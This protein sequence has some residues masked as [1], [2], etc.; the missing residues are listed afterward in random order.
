MSKRRFI[1]KSRLKRKRYF[2]ILFVCLF[3][4]GMGYANIVA[5]LDIL[6]LLGIR[7]YGVAFNMLGII[8]IREKFKLYSGKIFTNTG[9]SGGNHSENCA[10]KITLLSE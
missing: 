2:S 5:D 6:G 4:L 8:L 7:K 9:G 10:A 3:I 1:V